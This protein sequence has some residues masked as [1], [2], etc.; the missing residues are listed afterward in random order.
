MNTIKTKTI[1]E[2]IR[3][4][5]TPKRK[6]GVELY[7][8]PDYQRGYRWGENH[9]V[10]LLDDIDNFIESP[11]EYYCLQPIVVAKCLDKQGLSAWEVIDGQQRL[12]TLF[13]IFSYINKT[14]HMIEF[15]K[16]SESTSFLNGINIDNLKD[17]HPDLHF[18]SDCFKIAKKWFE[19]KEMNDVS[20]VD[21]FYVEVT[22]KVQVIWYEVDVNDY[23]KKIEIFERFNI[24][25]IPLTDSELIKALILSKIKGN[26][27]D[28]ELILRQSEISGEW[29]GIEKTLKK[30]DFW[31]FLCGRNPKEYSSRIEMI[32]NII[33]E[34]NNSQN[35]TTYLWF[36]KYFKSQ[37]EDGCSEYEI[38]KDLWEKI[39]RCFAKFNNWYNDRTTYHYIGYIMS[40]TSK[41]NYIEI[42]TQFLKKSESDK[43]SFKKYLKNQI[44]DSI[45]ELNFENVEYGVDDKDTQKLLLLFNILTVDGLSNIPQNRFP[46][47]LFINEKWS[48]EHIHAQNSEQIKDTKAIKAWLEE[49][50]LA[51]SNIT[52]FV[53]DTDNIEGDD[54]I[55]KSQEMTIDVVKNKID[56][57]LS[58]DSYDTDAFN[59]FKINVIE[60]F[61]SKSIHT[62]DNLALLTSKNNS[63]LNN[64]I[65]PVKRNRLI[66]LEKEGAFIPSCTRNV[67]LKLYSTSNNQP[68]Y[69]S[70]SDKEAYLTEIKTVINEFKKQ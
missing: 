59:M 38:A 51:I 46:F 3:S 35:Y 34:V 61:D 67:F 40:T 15:E 39:M 36:E 60:M 63:T 14:H 33:A 49:T 22:K 9:I 11:E 26:L 13:I 24:G 43:A 44:I 56:D 69:W 37:T 23:V 1:G 21:Q 52:D 41:S 20:Y 17:N 50:K 55:Y 54:T 12:I 57:F 45:K 68:Y 65:F 25:K 53:K 66:K 8:I 18:M 64:V 42:I 48:L 47:S 6:E 58:A 62:L 16:R 10:A 29:C 31:S 30:E 19:Q 2:L 32:F 4:S 27:S 5:Q 70:K 28:R 7:I